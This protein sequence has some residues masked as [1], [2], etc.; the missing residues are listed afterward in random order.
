MQT[1]VLKAFKFTLDPTPAQISALARHTGAA[2]WAF[3]HA[4][5]AKV[6]AHQDWQTQVATQVLLLVGGGNPPIGTA[7][8]QEGQPQLGDQQR[9]ERGRRR[10]L[11]AHGGVQRGERLPSVEQSGLRQR[12]AGQ[13]TAQGGGVGAQAAVRG[14]R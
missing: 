8:G 3:N 7:G 9:V 12:G 13:D 5:A 2:R 4:L 10:S 11:A 6:A 1:E 14:C